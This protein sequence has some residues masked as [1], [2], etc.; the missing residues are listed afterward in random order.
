MVPS[1][2]IL[3]DTS[4]NIAESYGAINHAVVFV[5]YGTENGTDYWIVRNSWGPNWGDHGYFRMQRGINLCQVEY[6]ASWIDVL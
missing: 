1:S 5:G 2:G 3:T 6:W 4:C